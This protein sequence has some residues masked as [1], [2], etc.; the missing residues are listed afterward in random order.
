MPQDFTPIGRALSAPARSDIVNL[1][2][3][4]SSRP[5]GELASAAGVSASTASEHLAILVDSGILAVEANGRR[6]MYR[7]ADARTAAALEQLGLLCPPAE[8]VGYYRTRDAR[9]LADARFCYDH[10]AGRLGVALT[11]SMS[12]H[13]WLGADLALS[14]TGD[15]A[16]TER[17]IDVAAL[18]AGRRRLTRPC[19]DWT[20]RR[21]HLAGAVGASVAA[22]FL[23]MKWIERG[24]PRAVR[25]TRAGRAALTDVWLVPADA[26]PIAL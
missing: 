21:P 19:A 3:D 26:V 2:M 7:V 5:A 8:D 22:H 11:E 12:E 15:A 4:G 17:G 14:P 25:V 1:L 23:A 6:R 16:L 13:G 10:L 20:E 24:H 18:R 9:R